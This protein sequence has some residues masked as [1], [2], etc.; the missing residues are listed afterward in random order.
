MTAVNY[1]V[2]CWVFRHSKLIIAR[3]TSEYVCWWVFRHSKLIVARKMSEYVRRW[4]YFFRKTGRLSQSPLLRTKTNEFLV[5]TS[6]HWGAVRKEMKD[7]LQ[8][9]PNP[10]Y[11]LSD[12]YMNAGCCCFC[13]V[14]RHSKLIIASKT[15]EHLH[16]QSN[17]D[18]MH[19]TQ[20]RVNDEHSL[21]NLN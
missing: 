8:F 17:F 1:T 10:H 16:L 5:L 7:R 21:H 18:M 19:T 12:T 6:A 9:K 13:W 15:S 20:G 3:K 4:V 14:F 11:E 2:C